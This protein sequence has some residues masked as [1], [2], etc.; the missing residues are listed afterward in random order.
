MGVCKTETTI[1]VVL[2]LNVILLLI[3]AYFLRN[4]GDNL[5]SLEQKIAAQQEIILEAIKAVE[6]VK[7]V[8]TVR[9]VQTVTATE[10]GVAGGS[11]AQAEQQGAEEKPVTTGVSPQLVAV[12]TGA[13]AACLDDQ[14]MERH[15]I[16]SI[17]SAT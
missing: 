12:I 5:Y 10:P 14:D 8:E 17:Q 2:V 16:A 11:V 1:I 3:V 4:N 6:A 15:S 13:I 9:E 7:V